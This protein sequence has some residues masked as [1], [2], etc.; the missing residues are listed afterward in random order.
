[1]LILNNQCIAQTFMQIEQKNKKKSP[2]KEMLILTISSHFGP[3][4]T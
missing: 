3:Q 4:I 1:M 2:N